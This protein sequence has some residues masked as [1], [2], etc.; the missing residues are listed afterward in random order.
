[1]LLIY[2]HENVLH[3]TNEKGLRW[4]YD[5]A[6]KPQFT[7]DYDYLF[8][9]EEDNLY[10]IEINDSTEIMSD[11][12]KVEIKEYI[13]LLEPPLS[14]TLAKQYIDDIRNETKDRVLNA[15][16][17]VNDHVSF[18]DRGDLMIAGREGSQDPRRQTARRVMEFQDFAYGLSERIIEELKET[19]DED[20]K[21]FNHYLDG[22]VI[23]PPVDHFF[24]EVVVDER[25]N[26][27]TLD[28]HGGED[29][30][31]FDKKAV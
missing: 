25:F 20:L 28:V 15:L 3:I 10:E 13:N 22:V 1:M 9:I 19:L 16:S 11:E 5:K 6:D 7:F 30:L 12:Q 2:D 18:H 21:D 29:D 14:L 8:Y 26:T 27:D 17:M 24:D 31:G 4:N 23:V